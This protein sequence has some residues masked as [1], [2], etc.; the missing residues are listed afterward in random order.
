MW[1]EIVGVFLISV[2]NCVICV[3]GRVRTCVGL[4]AFGYADVSSGWNVGV[5]SGFEF[6]F[7]GL[8]NGLVLSLHLNLVTVKQC[9]KLLSSN[10]TTTTTDTPKSFLLNC[11]MGRDQICTS[12]MLSQ[13][14]NNKQW[15]T[16]SEMVRGVDIKITKECEK[17]GLK[18]LLLLLLFFNRLLIQQRGSRARGITKLL[19]HSW[20]FVLPVARHCS[21]KVVKQSTRNR[22]IHKLKHERFL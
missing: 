21:L 19:L 11:Q 5:V 16:E 3:N 8:S 17:F 9:R 18:V 12:Y 7:S 6:P 20:A 14:W 22:R 15:K 1:K 13:R 2:Y 10:K 4:C